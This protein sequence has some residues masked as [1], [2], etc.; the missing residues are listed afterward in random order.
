MR[1]FKTGATRDS[2]LEL[3][4]AGGF[5]DGEGSFSCCKNNGKKFTR[6]QASIGQKNYNGKVSDTLIRFKNAVGVGKIFKKSRTGK[7]INQHQF[8]VCK[9]SDVKTFVKKILPHISKPKKDQIIR[10]NKLFF[11][12]TGKT[13]FDYEI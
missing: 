4:W 5:F 9:L 3:S 8:L 1:K 10:A 12:H 7:E 11:K 6:I 13:V 2:E